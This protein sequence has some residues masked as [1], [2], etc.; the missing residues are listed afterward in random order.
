[1]I[2]LLLVA[3]PLLPFN[4]RYGVMFSATVCRRVRR[5]LVCG[6]DYESSRWWSPRTVL[7]CR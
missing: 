5:G 2:T 4:T 1:M 6:Y 7:P 3:C